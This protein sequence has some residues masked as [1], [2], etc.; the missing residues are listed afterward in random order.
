MRPTADIE[1]DEQR[2]FH[3]CHIHRFAASA[4]TLFR[5][6]LLRNCFWT[7]TILVVAGLMLIALGFVLDLRFIVLGL[8][9]W[10]ICLPLVLAWC[11]YMYALNVINALNLQDH[12][13]R[14]G[15]DGIILTT[16]NIIKNY[17]DEGDNDN[18][19]TEKEIVSKSYLFPT[20]CLKGVEIY[21]QGYFLRI[22]EA[23]IRSIDSVSESTPANGYALFSDKAKKISCKEGWLFVPFTED[24][25]LIHN[26]RML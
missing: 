24:A 7:L 22:A 19:D 4:S 20:E 9:V 14:F 1:I 15:N 12:T 6:F 8:M 2:R 18:N 11:W 16:Y 23:E 25:S 10:C 26:I 13:L 17:D 3:E 21:G 5:F